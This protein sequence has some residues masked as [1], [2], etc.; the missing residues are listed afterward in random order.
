MT[1]ERENRTGHDGGWLWRMDIGDRESCTGRDGLRLIF[2][3]ATCPHPDRGAELHVWVEMRKARYHWVVDEPNQRPSGPPTW[4]VDTIEVPNSR[5]TEAPRD[6]LEHHTIRALARG[7]LHGESA[8]SVVHHLFWMHFVENDEGLTYLGKF[9]ARNTG[10]FYARERLMQYLR[11]N[12]HSGNYSVQ[13][14]IEDAMKEHNRT[15]GE[16]FAKRSREEKNLSDAI[17][18]LRMTSEPEEVQLANIRRIVEINATRMDHVIAGIVDATREDQPLLG[19]RACQRA[20]NDPEFFKTV[21]A[22]VLAHPDGRG[23][24]T[25]LK[26]HCKPPK[27]AK[28][29]HAEEVEEEIY[30]G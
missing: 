7:D 6:G 25:F 18:A 26:P 11:Y 29:A 19:L 13:C 5:R 3:P 17:S 1:F 15:L 14:A 2:E 10:N 16:R 27:K 12:H 8:A 21:D 30:D 4:S 22:F 24:V 23:M 20:E 28:R 9:A